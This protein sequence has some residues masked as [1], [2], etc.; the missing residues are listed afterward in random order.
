M[1]NVPD[2]VEVIIQPKD[3]EQVKQEGK[4]GKIQ[5]TALQEYQNGE[6]TFHPDIVNEVEIAKWTSE[7][8]QLY[9]YIKKY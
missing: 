4:I 7:I 6:N 2:D 8:S 9:K 1:L 3:E 5:V